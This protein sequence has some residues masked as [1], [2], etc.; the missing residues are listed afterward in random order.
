METTEVK[1]LFRHLWLWWILPLL[2]YIFS[3]RILFWYPI[4]EQDL[5][6]TFHSVNLGRTG[7]MLLPF[8]FICKVNWLRRAFHLWWVDFY[9]GPWLIPQSHVF[10]GF[11]G[12]IGPLS[13]DVRRCCG[14][15][16]RRSFLTSTI[17]VLIHRSFRFSSTRLGFSYNV[18]TEVL[19]F[20]A[21]AIH[22]ALV[23]KFHL[24]SSANKLIHAR[25]T[26]FRSRAARCARTACF[27]TGTA[28]FGGARTAAC[29]R[30]RAAACFS[31]PCTWWTACFGS[32]TAW[33]C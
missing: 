28:C 16:I 2:E 26:F 25:M 5:L 7:N 32:R 18:F 13:C 27:G 3:T 6:R 21:H 10:W 19:V 17:D 9:Y 11:L 31:R 15:N 30:A 33:H 24:A 14:W 8:A 1:F 4:F 12:V 22:V 23:F 20:P 29:F